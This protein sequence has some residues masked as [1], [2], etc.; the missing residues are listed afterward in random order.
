MWD[1]RVRRGEG[2]KGESLAEETR[3]C[4]V[5]EAVLELWVWELCRLW[6]AL[7]RAGEPLGAV[8]ALRKSP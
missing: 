2:R 6:A 4:L 7:G 1:L 5:V 8:Q 3:G